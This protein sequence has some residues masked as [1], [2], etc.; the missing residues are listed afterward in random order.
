MAGVEYTELMDKVRRPGAFGP[1]NLLALL[2]ECVAGCRRCGLWRGAPNTPVGVGPAS[3]RLMIVSLRPDPP[4]SEPGG[5][6]GGPT[7]EWLR[8]PLA[9][10]GIGLPDVYFAYAVKHLASDPLLKTRER[11]EG[12]QVPAL[13]TCRLWLE[14]EMA[15]VKP[16]VVLC[17]GSRAASAV[18]GFPIDPKND[19]GRRFHPGFVPTVLA[20]ETIEWFARLADAR[21]RKL[22]G[23]RLLEELHGVAEVLGVSDPFKG[24]DELAQ[25]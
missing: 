18:L 1:E 7:V 14:A 9:K 5:N 10:A 21:E 8:E 24:R 4:Q 2:R 19:R 17:L 6:A 16:E 22:A 12:Q 15:I 25:L 23:D 20:T 11:P 13:A 3:A